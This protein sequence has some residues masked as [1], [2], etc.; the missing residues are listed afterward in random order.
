MEAQHFYM[1]AVA[2]AAAANGTPTSS[3]V[4]YYPNKQSSQ[5]YMLGSQ[6][7]PTISPLL[8]SSPN[9]NSA[10]SASSSN[11][12]PN[13]S[14]VDVNSSTAAALCH[15]ASLANVYANGSSAPNSQNPSQFYYQNGQ[16]NNQSYSN[17][18]NQNYYT[19]Q[20]YQPAYNT[21]D[22][23]YADTNSW[24]NRLNSNQNQMNNQKNLNKSI[25]SLST[26]SFS[27]SVEP[28]NYI[29]PSHPLTPDETQSN[30]E[31]SNLSPNAMVNHNFLKSKYNFIYFFLIK[32]KKY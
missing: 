24:W 2:V 14:H 15:L 31:N 11:V 21:Y 13:N 12:S 22:Y 28:N 7:S 18:C 20:T 17:Q 8:S 6:V 27:S 4:S 16:F 3:N 25:S 29:V 26:S 19:Q 30:F 32:F 10:S 5:T 9:L 23:Q 1:Q